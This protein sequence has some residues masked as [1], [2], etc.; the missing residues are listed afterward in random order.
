MPDRS[1]ILVVGGYSEVGRATSATLI[2]VTNEVK[3]GCLPATG[4]SHDYGKAL[5]GDVEG[6]A[7]DCRY[8]DISRLTDFANVGKTTTVPSAHLVSGI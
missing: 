8:L 1:K 7:V 4:R 3:Q 2:D 5:G 6:D